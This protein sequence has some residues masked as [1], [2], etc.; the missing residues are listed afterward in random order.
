MPPTY[1]RYSY[2]LSLSLSLSLTHTHTLTHARTHTHKHSL[3]GGQKLERPHSSTK[4]VIS[5]AS[6][7]HKS[8]APSQALPIMS[9]QVS[10]E[11]NPKP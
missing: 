4:S 11:V 3:A 5:D 2:S 9:F 10:T 7:T 6:H 8:A 1:S